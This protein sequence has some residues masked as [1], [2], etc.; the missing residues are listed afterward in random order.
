MKGA[1]EGE[2]RRGLGEKEGD[3]KEQGSRKGEKEERNEA[4]QKVKS[5]SV[6][7]GSS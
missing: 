7:F 3:I 5:P 1:G 2:R 6:P 4:F